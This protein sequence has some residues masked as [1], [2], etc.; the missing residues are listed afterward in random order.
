M[1]KPLNS[2][3]LKRKSRI[4]DTLFLDVLYRQ[5]YRGPALFNTMYSK[6]PVQTI[7]AFLDD[8]TTF[9]QDL[10]IMSRFPTKPFVFSI[11]K[12]I[13]QRWKKF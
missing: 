4:Y 8:Q 5:N 13:A 10:F 9:K 12:K 6:I 7:F 2:G 1:N 11:L 3:L